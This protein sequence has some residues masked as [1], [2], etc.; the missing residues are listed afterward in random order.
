MLA[1]VTQSVCGVAVHD[2]K[3]FNSYS[4]IRDAALRKA[5][6]HHRS[7]FNNLFSDLDGDDGGA[8]DPC[9]QYTMAL[10]ALASSDPKISSS[11]NDSFCDTWTVLSE[12]TWSAKTL[13]STTGGQSPFWAKHTQS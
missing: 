12:T 8:Q 7:D 1:V 13:L 11:L 9:M 5:C 3:E 4:G 6:E 10:A 2:G